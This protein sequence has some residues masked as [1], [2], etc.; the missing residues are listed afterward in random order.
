MILTL[1][2]NPS[3]DR[4]VELP[5]RLERGA[6]QRA[7]A[8][9]D[10]V[11]AGK[12]INVARVLAAA[13]VPARAIV[14]AGADDR[15][16]GMLAADGVDAVCVPVEAAVRTNI[17]LTEADGTTTKINEPG[18]PLDEG[19]VVAM[20]DAVRANAAA[21][22]WLVIAGSLPT[23]ARPEIIVDAIGAARG[24]HA[25]IR[26]AVDTSGAP[27][28]AAIAAGGIDLAKPNDEE[29]EELL[30]LA[31]GTI[32]DRDDAA[33]AA[34]A[35][36]GRGVGTVLLTLG[37]AG[38]ILADAEHALHAVPPPT[39]VRS[40]VG[41]G[42]ASLAGWLIAAVRGDD[43]AGRLRQAVAHGSAAAALPGT[44]FPAPADADAARVAVA[45]VTTTDIPSTAAAAAADPQEH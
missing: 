27:L 16:A 33:A 19:A 40:T 35:L 2:L 32:A 42:D 20:L 45:S 14:M 18:A 9:A 22:D 34:C 10:E 26:I 28:A 25:G 30:G 6:V 7:A 12:G 36:V 23:G 5:S 21:A 43:A 8:A 1:T 31:P 24:A 44:G 37:G 39:E 13:G 29:L 15:F 4:T 17:A 3:I 38:A 41:A 11:A